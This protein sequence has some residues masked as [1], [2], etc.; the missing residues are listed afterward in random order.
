MQCGFPVFVW[1]GA[2]QILYAV[3]FLATVLCMNQITSEYP[4][5]ITKYPLNEARRP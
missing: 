4:I 1:T 2:Q 3:L 5:L